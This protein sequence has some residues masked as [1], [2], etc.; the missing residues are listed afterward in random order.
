M[1]GNIFFILPVR[2]TIMNKFVAEA[3][4]L[5]TCNAV[6]AGGCCASCSVINYILQTRRAWNAVERNCLH[7]NKQTQYCP[8][9]KYDI[10]VWGQANDTN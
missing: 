9:L 6:F 2:M 3:I 1:P 10:C 8:Y 7:T 5:V 4:S